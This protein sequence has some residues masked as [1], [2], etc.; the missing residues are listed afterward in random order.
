MTLKARNVKS[1]ATGNSATVD[2]RALLIKAAGEEFNAAGY[3]G[4]DTNR[5]ARHAGFAPQ[6]FYRHF[7]DKLDIFL[8]VYEIWRVDENAAIAAAIKASSVNGRSQAIAAVIIRHHRDWAMFRRSLRMLA[9]DEPRVRAA[10]AEGRKVQLAALMALPANAAQSQAALVRAL[11]TIERLCDALADGE[12]EDLGIPEAQW[13][14]LVAR[15]V[16]AARGD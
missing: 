7:A 6:T 12:V 4:T 10:R 11:L 5:I 1:S 9:A 16:A 15:A 2:T 3:F 14:D 13:I 8:A